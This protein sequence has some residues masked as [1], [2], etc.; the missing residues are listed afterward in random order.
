MIIV[1]N[2][3]MAQWLLL[4][5]LA[6]RAHERSLVRLQFV[7]PSRWDFKK[8][9]KLLV[10]FYRADILLTKYKNKLKT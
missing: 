10:A 8:K 4:L 7:A 3:S 9:T 1:L 5:N 2:A 6:L